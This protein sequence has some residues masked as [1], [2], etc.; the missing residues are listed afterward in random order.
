MH[1]IN[2]ANSL[3]KRLANND[4]FFGLWAGL[5][6]FTAYFCMYMYRKPFTAGSYEQLE[7]FGVDYKIILV[8]T[9]VLGYATSK[10]IGIKLISELDN[11]KRI[12]LFLGLIAI[13]WFAL[14]GFAFTPA[15]W[16]WLWLFINGLPLGLIWGI[17]FSYC[18]GRKLTEVLTVMLSANFILSSGIA[19]S[20]GK[21][22]ILEGIPER[23]MPM[24]T[25]LL[26]FP[27]LLI[28]LWMLQKI[29]PPLGKDLQLRALRKPMNREDRLALIKEFKLP[30]GLFITIYLV[31]T[32]IRDIRDNFAV[33]IWERLGFGESPEIFST[34]ELP[35]TI[36]I[37]L[38][39]GF[40]YKIKDNRKALNYNLLIST[41]GFIL[42]LLSTYLYKIELLV[43]VWWMI[44]SGIGLFLPYILLNGILFDRFI[45]TYRITGNVGFIMYMADAT[46][47][48]GSIAILV[49]K[50]F[51]GGSL[52][53]LDF[54][55][56]LCYA[57]SIIGVILLAI[58]FWSFSN[59]FAKS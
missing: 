21:A 36:A 58:L 12:R 50:N 54:Y 56:Q 6:C 4:L 46:G 33:E 34:T 1:E 30:L 57:G 49:Y 13:A 3:Q 51:G 59:Y 5:A 32:I 10:L 9:Q 38:C 45:A 24:L 39:L 55:I 41:F 47:Y 7:V 2:V 35:V 40:L 22:M 19:K 37:L 53:W 43:A 20:I 8:I 23:F 14:V 48:F 42:L 17:V 15:S 16:A 29:P 44:L 27:L 52:N 28:A 25:G 31:L 26:V 11:S 18:E